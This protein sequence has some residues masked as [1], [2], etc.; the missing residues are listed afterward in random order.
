MAYLELNVEQVTRAA[1]LLGP[2][3]Q[4]HDVE[5]SLNNVIDPRIDLSTNAPWA[6]ASLKADAETD[7]KTS[8][9][10]KCV[11]EPSVYPDIPFEVARYLA[12]EQL[13]LRVPCT[14]SEP[15]RKPVASSGGSPLR[16]PLSLAHNVLALKQTTIGNPQEWDTETASTTESKCEAAAENWAGSLDISHKDL[17][18]VHHWRRESGTMSAK[19]D[20][21]SICSET[22][23]TFSFWSKDGEL[24]SLR[25]TVA[26]QTEADRVV[27]RLEGELES[28][29]AELTRALQEKAQLQLTGARALVAEQEVKGGTG[30][31]QVRDLEER[32]LELEAEAMRYRRVLCDFE[33]LLA[34]KDSEAE[35]LREEL[36]QRDRGDSDLRAALEERKVELEARTGASEGLKLKIADLHVEV[37]RMK[38]EK[39]KLEG[40]TRTLRS[41]LATAQKSKEWFRQQL[42]ESQQNRDEIHRNH[43]ACQAERIALAAEVQQLRTAEA[44]ARREVAALNQRS[45]EEKA[46]LAHRLEEI[47]AQWVATQSTMANNV[48]V[49]NNQ[50]VPSAINGPHTEE[51]MADLEHQLSGLMSTLAAK[52]EAL[53]QA[54]RERAQSAQELHE[55]KLKL[56]ESEL[57]R[58]QSED[59]LQH[60]VQSE[61]RLQAEMCKVQEELQALRSE[62]AQTLSALAAANEEKAVVQA[63]VSEMSANIAGLEANFKIMHSQLLAKCAQVEELEKARGSHMHTLAEAQPQKNAVQETSGQTP[64]DEPAGANLDSP[65][66]RGRMAVETDQL[67][68]ACEEIEQESAQTKNDASGD[69]FIARSQKYSLSVLA[70]KLRETRQQLQCA[71]AE[72]EQYR[73]S[74]AAMAK[75]H[76]NDETSSAEIQR[77]LLQLE[78]EQGKLE[79]CRQAQGQLGRHATELEKQLAEKEAQLAQL[80]FQ[81]KQ[82]EEMASAGLQLRDAQMESLCQEL[83]KEQSLTKDTRQKVYEEKKRCARLNSLLNGTKDALQESKAQ[84]QAKQLEVQDLQKQL[85]EKEAALVQVSSQCKGLMEQVALEQHR[86]QDLES[87]LLTAHERDPALEQHMKLLSWKVK[88]ESQQVAALKE[89]A[90]RSGEAH[91]E[92]IEAMRKMLQETQK[93]CQTL[94]S[95]LSLARK[96][97]LALVAHLQEVRAALRSRHDQY[98]ELQQELH[99]VAESAKV[100]QLPEPSP[101]QDAYLN[102]LLQQCALLSGTGPL[103]HLQDCLHSLKQDLHT[104]QSQV[105]QQ[106]IPGG[107][108]DATS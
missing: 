26:V 28:L 80:S 49:S 77:L 51:R 34:Q 59:R 81:L 29:A 98:K 94:S 107:T 75:P 19:D 53:L 76:E 4:A 101:Y 41:E 39:A 89:Q 69:K 64:S 7:E 65:V 36:T 2:L 68:K 57:L 44:R 56:G 82:V 5:D 6:C 95:E 3:P 67:V 30:M 22:E 108:V 84:V 55:V 32:V 14:V 47:Q 54:S 40:Q 33:G 42:H 31:Q 16:A 106:S 90:A 12:S 50:T 91:Q 88:E 92:E 103:G 37:Q 61:Q 35:A 73:L 20:T 63:S 99:E 10:Q 15:N 46:E 78:K 11:E 24:Q 43:V 21:H 27:A 96:E 8:P 18:S 9:V 86:A 17:P 85:Q 97:K 100:P 13:D 104:L 62:Q 102:R 38:D 71:Q 74:G 60:S 105:K 93:R 45:L 1:E 23:S 52:D 66:D 72:L 79:G 25:S 70:R 48:D 58:L 83:S 87:Q